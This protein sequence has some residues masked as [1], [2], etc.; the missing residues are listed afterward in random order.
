MISKFIKNKVLWIVLFGVFLRII[1]ASFLYHTDIKAI[2]R[3][4]AMIEGGIKLGYEKAAAANS[5]LFYPP[6]AY[7]F[8]E[9]YQKSFDFLFSDYFETWMSDWGSLH[10]QNHP[11][12]F[13]DLLAM[14]LPLIIFDVLGGFLIVFFSDK[15]NRD[16]AAGLWFLNPVSLYAIYAFSQYDVIV[17]FILIAAV[18]LADK[19]QWWG[20]AYLL[21]GIAASWKQIPLLIFPFLF[22]ADPRNLF[23]KFGGLVLGMIAY[24]ALLS[25]IITSRA[26]LESVFLYNLNRGMFAAGFDLGNGVFLSLFMVFYLALLF[27]IY[28]NYLKLSLTEMITILLGGLFALSLFNPQWILWVVGPAILLLLERKMDWKMVM[29]WSVFYFGSVFLI[30][31]KFVG[32]GLLKG[33]NNAFDWVPSFYSLASKTY[34][35]DKL[36]IF[37]RGGFLASFIMITW[38]IISK[39]DISVISSR[40]YLGRIALAWILGI[41]VI[42]LGA[43]MIL[44]ATGFYIDNEHVGESKLI[45]L[46]EDVVVEQRF[47]VENSGLVGIE[48]RVKNISMKSKSDV[49]FEIWNAE[50]TAIVRTKTVNGSLIGDDYDLIVNFPRVDDSANKDYWLLIKGSGIWVNIDSELVN[51]G[52]KIDGK[53]R[54][55]RLSYRVLYNPGGFGENLSYSLRNIAEKLWP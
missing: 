36:I 33:I 4:S 31:D 8:F 7:V 47:K 22:L 32:L 38:S 15:K 3:D 21:L 41:T 9:R 25:P 54:P 37:A 14:K 10:T 51:G 55:G 30:N 42:F 52:L 34:L 26:G 27:A 46:N 50:K 1:F 53:E 20:W 39:K 48:I 12:L 17:V 13:Q 24:I 40:V 44:P 2:Y 43:H 49:I 23:K 45:A 16:M 19:K 5:P 28:F 6:V 29:L 35:V 18:V 11:Q